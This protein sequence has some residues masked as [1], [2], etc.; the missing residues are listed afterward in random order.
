MYTRKLIACM[1]LVAL[2]T[3][4]FVNVECGSARRGEP[5]K[6]PMNI[7]SPE[8]ATGQR[9]FMKNCHECHPGAEAG[10]A[11][12]INDMPLPGFLIKFQVRRGMG[13]MPGFSREKIT[14]EELEALV[15]YIKA[16]RKHG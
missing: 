9:V 6:G 4:L 10:F 13:E 7:S 15:K 16:M 1:P 5:L 3:F 2:F 11:P 12:A 14:D 8:I